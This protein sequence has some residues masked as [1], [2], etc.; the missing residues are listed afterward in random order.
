MKRLSTKEI[1]EAITRLNNNYG[2]GDVRQ[3]RRYLDGR[4]EVIARLQYGES[5]FTARVDG[6]TVYARGHQLTVKER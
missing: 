6:R 2:R 5:K 3:V 4:I 1:T